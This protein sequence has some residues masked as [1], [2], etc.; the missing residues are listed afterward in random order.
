MILSS[1]VLNLSVNP[2]INILYPPSD[3]FECSTAVIPVTGQV[4]CDDCYLTIG[5][6]RVAINSNGE[7]SSPIE[8]NPGKNLIYIS[9]HD[10]LGKTIS[11]RTLNVVR[12]NSDFK[13][14]IPAQSSVSGIDASLVPYPPD[15]AQNA[16][17]LFPGSKTSVYKPE[18]TSRMQINP[19]NKINRIAYFIN[20]K[21]ILN[22]S[23]PETSIIGK[24]A[25]IGK[26]NS[27]FWNVAG[28][29]TAEKG[30]ILVFNGKTPFE[31]KLDISEYRNPANGKLPL[32]A[33]FEK[34]GWK[35]H[36]TPGTINLYPACTA[37]SISIGKGK[38]LQGIMVKNRVYL[39][40]KEL[41]RGGLGTVADNDKE[42]LL[43]IEGK[44]K[45]VQFQQIGTTTPLMKCVILRDLAQMGQRIEWDNDKKIAT[46][47]HSIEISRSN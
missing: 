30:D 17:K 25:L 35:V 43:K 40:G 6:K 22:E 37:V 47:S 45:S 15:S 38:R 20:G 29:Q 11:T 14:K 26:N 39:E 7:F 23:T 8:I 2:E 4:I 41:E 44:N 31:K 1:A 9:T 3:S 12:T 42:A 13:L 19:K 46:V 24:R 21:R 28:V 10:N 36:W 5:E 33:V 32:R 18:K 34:A 16:E 27:N